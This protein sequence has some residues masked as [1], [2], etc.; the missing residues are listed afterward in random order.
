MST[1]K[2][3]CLKSEEETSETK[4]K[5][6]ECFFQEPYKYVRNIFDQPKSGV[7]KTEKKVLEK[8]SKDTSDPNR[9]IPL[10]HNNLFG[11]SSLR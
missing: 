6:Q 3:V 8:H 5:K 10:E 1:K 9:H 7:L 2:R 4:E 11:Q